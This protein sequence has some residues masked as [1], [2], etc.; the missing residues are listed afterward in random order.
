LPEATF[1]HALGLFGTLA[2]DNPHDA[3]ADVAIGV[4]GFGVGTQG[5]YVAHAETLGG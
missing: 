5:V 1:I 3:E 4:V 2:G